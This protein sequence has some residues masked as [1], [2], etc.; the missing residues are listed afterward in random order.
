MPTQTLSVNALPS[1][2]SGNINASM[3]T[4]VVGESGNLEMSVSPSASVPVVMEASTTP[5]GE[6]IPEPTTLP[7]VC[8]TDCA[9][10]S[11]D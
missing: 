3:A 6:V 8:S 2:D 10:K 7:P 4:N 11:E 9:G 1:V 5:G